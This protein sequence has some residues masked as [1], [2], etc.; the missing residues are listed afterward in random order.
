MV[1]LSQFRLKTA[2]ADGKPFSFGAQG[3]AASPVFARLR[4]SIPTTQQ[5]DSSI[6]VTL[7]GKARTSEALEAN[8]EATLVDDNQSGV[9]SM[10][11]E[12]RSRSQ[13]IQD[14]QKMRD[15][16]ALGSEQQNRLSAEIEA[17]DKALRDIVASSAFQRLQGTLA[18]VESGFAAGVRSIELAGSLM[19]NASFLGSDFISRVGNGDTGNLSLFGGYVSAIANAINSDGERDQSFFSIIENSISGAVKALSGSSFNPQQTGISSAV[20]ATMVAPLPSLEQVRFSGSDGLALS[21][22]GYIGSDAVQA[23]MAHM[24]YDPRNAVVLLVDREDHQDDIEKKA[25]KEADEDNS[26]LSAGLRMP[27]N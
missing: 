15:K 19:E 1:D 13:R 24:D 27:A 12:I 14:L 26:K 9:R 2:R 3:A 25:K 21:I 11:Q 6:E 4:A 8:E 17:E 16:A 22:Q 18:G 10:F 23:A 7:R 5:E 20:N